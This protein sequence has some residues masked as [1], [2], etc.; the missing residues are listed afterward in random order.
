MFIVLEGGECA[1][2]GTQL[3]MLADALREKNTKVIL[4][5][6][7]TKDGE[8]GKFARRELASGS[9]ID[10]RTLQFL[11]MTDRSEHVEKLINPKLAEGFTVI[12]D[13]YY[14]ST[15]VYGAAFGSKLGLTMD[16]L[17]YMND[18]FPKADHI[19]YI[20]V[21]PEVALERIQK[22]KG[23]EERFDKLDNLKIIHA[24]Y[25]RLSERYS[26]NVWHNING[27]QTQEQVHAEI[28]SVWEKYNPKK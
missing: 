24:E 2:K 9:K 16:N 15:V 22:R 19:F 14:Q 4:T 28:M 12:S 6:E 21:P 20:N 25:H 26:S 13:R 11:F 10:V 17:I 8:I 1:G 27:N 5:E 18:I 23:A 3:Q 7:P